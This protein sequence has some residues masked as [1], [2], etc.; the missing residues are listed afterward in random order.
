[1]NIIEIEPFGLLRKH[2]KA[3]VILAPFTG[4]DLNS[5]EKRAFFPQP[6]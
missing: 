6:T 1:M 2:F 4:C 3:L 5:N